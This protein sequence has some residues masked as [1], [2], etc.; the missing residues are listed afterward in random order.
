MN[1]IKDSIP[2]NQIHFLPCKISHKGYAPVST[3][4]NPTIKKDNDYYKST[5]R[6]KEFNGKQVNASMQMAVIENIEGQFIITEEKEFSNGY[7]WEFDQTP[8]NDN[9]FVSISYVN[10]SL[11]VLE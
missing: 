7:I 4:F 11:S 5:F 3:F 1:F 10:R 8:L 2:S 9:V 6:G